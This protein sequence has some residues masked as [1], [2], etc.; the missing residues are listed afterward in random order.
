MTSDELRSRA[1]MTSGEMFGGP[2]H[3]LGPC[4]KLVGEFPIGAGTLGGLVY[5]AHP[6]GHSSKDFVSLTALA[7]RPDGA[8]AVISG[9]LRLPVGALPLLAAAIADAM[10]LA[11]ER[12]RADLGPPS[13]RAHRRDERPAAE[14]AEQQRDKAEGSAGPGAHLA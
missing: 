2:R 9:T 4:E 3:G 14:S 12:R 5:S 10:D 7:R 8:R 11:V 1:R 13:L 6:G